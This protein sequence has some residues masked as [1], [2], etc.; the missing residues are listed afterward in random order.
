[1]LLRLIQRRILATTTSIATHFSP[2]I[3]SRRLSTA[4]VS[5][6][7]QDDKSILVNWR[8]GTDSWSQFHFDW[9]RDNCPCPKCKHP[10]YGQRLLDTLEDPTPANVDVEGSEAVEVKWKDGHHSRYPYSWLLANTYCHNNVAKE[11]GNKREITLWDSSSTVTV[12]PPGVN[13]NDVVGDDKKL[14]TLLKN[15]YQYGFCFVLET[16]CTK[17]SMME[18]AN[19]IGPIL[20]S[21]YGLQWYIV[22]GSKYIKLVSY[23]HRHTMQHKPCAN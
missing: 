13:Y 10:E 16:P 18:V 9:L 4:A 11:A 5:K 7:D 20:N 19:K 17:E 8:K 22:A 14:L 21:Y 23:M 2:V 12:N 6:I 1:M 15:L 3:S